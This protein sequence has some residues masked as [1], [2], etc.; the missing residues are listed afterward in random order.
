MNLIF[1]GRVG[2]VHQ[3][4]NRLFYRVSSLYITYRVLF[5]LLGFTLSAFAKENAEKPD[6]SVAPSAEK[7]SSHADDAT[8]SD[9]AKTWKVTDA[10]S[11]RSGPDSNLPQW[12]LD[13][14][15]DCKPGKK[16]AAN[17]NRTPSRVSQII[18]SHNED[19]T[20]YYH[21]YLKQHPHV[22]GTLQVRLRING[23]GCV[24][25]VQVVHSTL[26]DKEFCARVCKMIYSW[27]N[28]GASDA[29]VK[30]YRQEYIFGDENQPHP[31]P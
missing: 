2:D 4:G 9:K 31:H 22:A 26:Q 12:L 8:D 7:D 23:S 16:P 25:S 1:L 13:L 5:V 15:T 3:E 17:N 21:R 19:I 29:G 20:D 27:D 10:G 30:I 11:Q 14:A 18:N 6:R 28:F 24:D